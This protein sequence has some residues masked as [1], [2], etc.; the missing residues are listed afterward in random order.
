MKAALEYI[1]I[2]STQQSYYFFKQSETTFLPYW[3]YHPELELTLISKGNGTRFIGDSISSF[4]DFDLVL[5][6]ENLA[7]HWV[8]ASERQDQE[9]YVFQF[10]KSLFHN[11]QECSV[12]DPLFE[13]AKRGIHFSK[14]SSTLISKI[15]NFE[16]LSALARLGSILDILHDLLN[17]DEKILLAS[18]DYTNQTLGH[19]S[20]SKISKTTNYIL[21]HLDEQLTV[22]RMAA[23]THMVPQS[24]CRW[25]KKHSGH[26]FISF[27]NQ[28]RIEKV[29]H[30]LVSKSTPIQDIAF[31]S[32]FETLS[33]FNRIF[34]RYKNC[35]PRTYRNRFQIKLND[36]PDLQSLK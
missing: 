24:F 7:H 6:G 3:H 15:K 22:N 30:E 26:S 11:F 16:S 14:P 35:S 12:L 20:Q 27:L 31:S 2:E 19:G 10:D 34:K 36:Q 8:S 29:C 1:P 5:V 17:E 9:A 13:N 25:F 4:S 21:E 18:E 32:G 33:H 28:T 23:Y